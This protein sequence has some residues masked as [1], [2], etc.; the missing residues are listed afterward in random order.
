[1]N[2]QITKLG[3]DTK[4][5]AT[6]LIYGESGIGKTSL[7]KT[8]PLTSDEKLLYIAVD[9][10]QLSLRDR[11]NFSKAQAPN[12]VWSKDYLTA[13]YQYIRDNSNKFEWV[14]ID[15]LDDLGDAILSAEKKRTANQQKAY[16]EMADFMKEWTLAVRDISGT[17]V[18]LITHISQDKDA[19][20]T[21]SFGPSFP[22][23][24]FTNRLPDFFDFIGCMRM[25]ETE[26]GKKRMLQFMK[27][28]DPRYTVKERG[29]VVNPLEPP[30]LGAILKRL[31]EAGFRVVDES[32]KRSRAELKAAGELMKEKGISTEQV[33][34]K[35][36]KHPKEFDDKL[37]KEFNSWLS[38]Q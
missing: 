17:N 5:H 11:P 36:G 38:G 2:I 30:D 24:A 37:W 13:L 31:Q 3:E 10:G 21:L 15:G 27:E 23:K 9:P 20:N 34:A 25:V 33:V 7:A 26:D 18:I 16:G 28:A 22:G 1:M 12:G 35:Y 4:K 6:F 19:T 32:P 14:F 8:L 29:G